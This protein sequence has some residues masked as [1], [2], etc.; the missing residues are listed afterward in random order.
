MLGVVESDILA[1][2]IQMTLSAPCGERAVPHTGHDTGNDRGQRQGSGDKKNATGPTA[3][4]TRHFVRDEKTQ[5]QPGGSLGQADGSADG[6]ILRKF[7]E[8]KL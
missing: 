2:R 1:D 4:F 6:K 3:R 5:S 7:V 8:G